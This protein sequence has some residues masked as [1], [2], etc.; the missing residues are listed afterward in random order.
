[1]F[2]SF[3]VVRSYSLSCLRVSKQNSPAIVASLNSRA[4]QSKVQLF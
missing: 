2:S 1:M 3:L 4:K